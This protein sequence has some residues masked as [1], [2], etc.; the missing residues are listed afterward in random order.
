MQ[1]VDLET[2]SIKVRDWPQHNMARVC[3]VR[4]WWVCWVCWAACVLCA[5]VSSWSMR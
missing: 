3:G 4:V 5:P 2:P 1:R